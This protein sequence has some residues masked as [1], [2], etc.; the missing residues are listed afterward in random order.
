MKPLTLLFLS[1]LVSLLFAQDPEPTIPISAAKTALQ[2][3]Q[4]ADPEKRAAAYRTFQLFGKS[5]QDLYRKTLNAARD[6]H[7]DKLERLMADE[8]KNPFTN[9][10]ELN[11]QLQSERTRIYQ[12]IKIDYQKDPAKITMLRNEVE[13]LQRLNEQ[14]HKTVNK[15][16]QKLDHEAMVI[17]Q[18]LAEVFRELKRVEDEAF[19]NEELNPERALNECY[20]GGMYLKSKKI[21]EK[22]RSEIAQSQKT[23]DDNE[24]ATWAN[25]AQKSFAHHLNV[26][27]SL[28]GLTPLLLEQNLSRAAMGHSQDMAAHGF[29][30]HTSPLEGKQSPGDRARK[31]GF[32]YGWTGENIFMGSSSHVSAYNAW[33]GSDGH[34]FIMFASGPNLLGIGPH[35]NHWTMMTGRK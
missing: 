31:A 16:A 27:R 34:R 35:G 11:D 25:S 29:F 4:N 14:I 13:S 22:L 9:L 3:M 15:D 32:E 30:S 21:V 1:P 19:E 18:S 33:F 26:F 24:K 5:S 6:L 23:F 17:G 2:W 7:E 28:F 10:S 8:R 12:L 20:E